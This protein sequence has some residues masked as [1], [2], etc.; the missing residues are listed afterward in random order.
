MM[1][2]SATPAPWEVEKFGSSSGKG[3]GEVNSVS[4]SVS[5]AEGEAAATPSP[6]P[7]ASSDV[8]LFGSPSRSDVE[9]VAASSSLDAYLALLCLAEL[10]CRRRLELLAFCLATN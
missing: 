3:V 4:R 1:K 7:V 2:R 10:R 9:E 8:E 5:P 6:P